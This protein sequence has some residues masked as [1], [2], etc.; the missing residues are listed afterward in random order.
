MGF[1]CDVAKT[2]VSHVVLLLNVEMPSQCLREKLQARKRGFH[3]S[4][5]F[6]PAWLAFHFI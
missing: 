4:Q 1:Q 2:L 6:A 3:G 5:R